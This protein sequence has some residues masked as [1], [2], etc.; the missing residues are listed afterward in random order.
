MT[1]VDGSLKVDSSLIE[2]NDNKININIVEPTSEKKVAVSE[3]DS[4]LRD[5]IYAERWLNGGSRTYSAI[6]NYSELQIKYQPQSDVVSFSVPYVNIPKE[7]IKIHLANPDMQLLAKYVG[8]STASFFIHPQFYQDVSVPY[9]DQVC[10][11]PQSGEVEVSPTSSSR[12]TLVIDNDLHPH[13]IKLHCPIQISRFNRKLDGR[14]I[15]KSV[16]TSLELERAIKEENFPACFGFLPETI[17]VSIGG[18]YSDSWGFI[19]REMTPRPKISDEPRTLVPMFSLYSSDLQ[20]DCPTTP[21]LVQLIEKSGMKPQ[22]FI[23]EKI[24]LRIVESW[25]FMARDLG[26]L[27]QAH[28]QNLLLELDDNGIPTRVIFRD[29]STY[30]DRD[31][32]TSKGLSNKNFPLPGEYPSSS[33]SSSDNDDSLSDISMT[34]EE[35][36]VDIDRKNGYYSLLYDSFVGHHLFD[37]IA[38]V[39][40][41]HYDIEIESLQEACKDKFRKCFPEHETFFPNTVHYYSKD[42]VDGI[43]QD[44]EDTFI[45]PTWR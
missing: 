16:G 11:F 40:N 26:I 23:L 2:H 21:L 31:L 4:K 5:F 10:Q 15:K 45:K 22:E 29:L 35:L 39:A 12:T 38:K 33:S 34:E 28:G 27:A 20:K 42:C 8:D 1:K 13:C 44:L 24:M 32:R 43:R 9:M 3:L 14:D 19:L 36:P 17:G 25:C 37:Y 30:M 41:E 6:A 7:Y 18:A